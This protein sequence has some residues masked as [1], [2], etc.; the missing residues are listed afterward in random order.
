MITKQILRLFLSIILGPLN[1]VPGP[2]VNQDLSRT[3][4]WG[5]ATQENEIWKAKGLL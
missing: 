2:G 5:V 1:D 4:F 3:Q